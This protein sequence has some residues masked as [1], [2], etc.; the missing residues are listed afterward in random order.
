MGYHL[1]QVNKTPSRSRLEGRV[2]I[3]RLILIKLRAVANALS[4]NPIRGASPQLSRYKLEG[5]SALSGGGGI[6]CNPECAW[7]AGGSATTL[8]VPTPRAG[9][10]VASR[11]DD[12]PAADFN[13][14]IGHEFNLSE[15]DEAALA[16]LTLSLHEVFKNFASSMFVYHEPGN[17]ALIS[18]YVPLFLLAT[19]SNAL[20]IG[21]VSKYNHLRRYGKIFIAI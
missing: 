21:V 12:Q 13:P 20:V 16:N 8:G 19:I 5:Q 10:S 7:P 15:V 14:F 9:G 2:K 1:T 17:I 6:H 4:G 11:M 18:C 3:R